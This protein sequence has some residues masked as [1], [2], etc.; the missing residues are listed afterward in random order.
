MRGFYAVYLVIILRYDSSQPE[1]SLTLNVHYIHVGHPGYIDI[2]P[3]D[4][5]HSQN[6]E[7]KEI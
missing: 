5:E 1:K 4:L 2:V 3:D 6:L 7:I